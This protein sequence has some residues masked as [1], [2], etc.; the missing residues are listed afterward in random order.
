MLVFK[1]KKKKNRCEGA[2]G[3]VTINGQPRDLRNFRRKSCYIMQEDLVQPKLTV[4]EAMRFAADL[5]LGGK[6]ESEIRL[7]IVSILYFTKKK[8][9]FS[10]YNNKITSTL[11]LTN[12]K[13]KNKFTMFEILL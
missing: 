8:K 7:K 2:A 4:L 6:V 10:F 12:G 11:Y 5:K 13:L 3:I 1:I 9:K